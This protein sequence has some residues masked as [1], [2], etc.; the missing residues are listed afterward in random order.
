MKNPRWLDEFIKRGGRI[1]SDT[2]APAGAAGA[3]PIKK[4]AGQNTLAEEARH[5]GRMVDLTG[6]LLVRIV[7]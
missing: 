7:R 4:R 2:G 1:R 6:S 5:K 3:D